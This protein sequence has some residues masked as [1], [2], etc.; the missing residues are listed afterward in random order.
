MS[1]PLTKL[2]LLKLLSDSSGNLSVL[3][4]QIKVLKEQEKNVEKVI[5]SARDALLKRYPQDIK[6]VN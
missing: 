3:R 6:K 4:R 2:E 5:E 1:R